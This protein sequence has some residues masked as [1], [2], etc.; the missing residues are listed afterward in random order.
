MKFDVESILSKWLNLWKT[1][2]L[3]QVKD[4]FLKSEKLTY[5]SSET[6]GIIQGLEAV[7]SH[8]VGF[9]FM[10]GGKPH[11]NK[12]WLE[13]INHNI[14]GDTVIV[15]GIWCFQRGTDQSIQRG[16]VT[17]LYVLASE[18]NYKI[19]HMNFGNYK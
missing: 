1:Y 2:D 13:D 15:N 18:G 6:E 19:A 7:E 8:H 12:L 3:D 5:F 14:F 10:S 9:G 16:P 17:I 11:D 4:L